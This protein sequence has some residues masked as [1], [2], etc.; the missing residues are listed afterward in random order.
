MA[1]YIA[2]GFEF[3]LDAFISDTNKTTFDEDYFIAIC[4]HLTGLIDTVCV[5]LGGAQ[6]GTMSMSITHRV[7]NSRFD[8]DTTEMMM[9][10]IQRF[11][12]HRRR[13]IV[14]ETAFEAGLEDG[15]LFL[16]QDVKTGRL[17]FEGLHSVLST[18]Y[19]AKQK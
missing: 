8:D 15:K 6:G 14:F 4:G 11:M 9:K 19:S 7:L 12:T 5:A 3:T 17:F 2:I 16:D 13:P 10:G 1:E 18:I